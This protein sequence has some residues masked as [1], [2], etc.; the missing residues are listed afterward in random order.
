[1]EMLSGPFQCW[2]INSSFLREVPVSVL[3]LKIALGGSL[4]ASLSS[5]LQ[6]SRPHDFI[7]GKFLNSGTSRPSSRLELG[8]I[9]CTHKALFANWRLYR[10]KDL[11]KNKI[12]DYVGMEF[13][14]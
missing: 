8:L 12:E 2:S 10:Y 4:G 3:T 9:P 5:I 14:N 13:H 6:Y 11:Q 1:M 7:F